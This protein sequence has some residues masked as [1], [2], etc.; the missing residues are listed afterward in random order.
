MNISS[1]RSV[2]STSIEAATDMSTAW[3]VVRRYSR[4][5][6]SQVR[7]SAPSASKYARTSSSSCARRSSVSRLMPRKY[8]TST[9]GEPHDTVCQ[10]TTVSGRGAPSSPQSMLSSR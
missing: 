9:I 7:P 1:P 10:S 6:S 4:Q 3:N 8:A 2:R 5:H